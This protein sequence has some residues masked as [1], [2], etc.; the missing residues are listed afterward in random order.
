[1]PANDQV[2][3][4]PQITKNDPTIRSFTSPIIEPVVGPDRH[5]FHAHTAILS[6]SDKLKAMLKGKWKNNIE[7]KIVQ[8]DWDPET[9]AGLLSWIYTADYDWPEPQ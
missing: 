6:K 1:M 7:F 4:F 9:I 5:S 3:V 2:N 8:E